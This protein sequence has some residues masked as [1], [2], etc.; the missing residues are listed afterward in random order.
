MLKLE[1]E[2]KEKELWLEE[3]R[4]EMER[5]MEEDRKEI[6]RILEDK[7]QKKKEKE[8]RKRKR[9]EYSE[10]EAKVRSFR[11]EMKEIQD[12]TYQLALELA[13]PHQVIVQEPAVPA[14]P[15]VEVSKKLPLIRSRRKMK[16]TY[17]VTVS[18]REQERLSVLWPGLGQTVRDEMNVDGVEVVGGEVSVVGGEEGVVEGEEG[19]GRDEEGV[20]GGEEGVVEGE[21]GVFGGKEGA[22]GGEEGVIGDEKGV[23][24][25]EVGVGRG[26]VSGGGKK[27][28]SCKDDID[29]CAFPDCVRHPG[30]NKDWHDDGDVGE[31]E[32]EDEVFEGDDVNGGVDDGQEFGYAD[33][34]AEVCQDDD[35]FQCYLCY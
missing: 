30:V 34:T 25:G 10:S 26:E 1:E 31:G 7:E 22:F 28:R 5:K 3:E 33:E 16:G 19:V 23:G 13:E 20:G 17:T 35:G 8:Q 15:D 27:V 29:Q 9:E 14:V 21:E 2:R 11:K 18:E 12:A 4:K 24:G 32:V 6:E